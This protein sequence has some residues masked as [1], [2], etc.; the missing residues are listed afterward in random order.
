MNSPI[1]GKT[2]V[3]HVQRFN[4]CGPP[5]HECVEYL[6]EHKGSEE[7]PVVNPREVSRE[8]YAVLDRGVLDV[9]LHGLHQRCEDYAEPE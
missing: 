6:V 5:E 9:V 3:Q 1:K 7:V 4:G 8:H 2:I